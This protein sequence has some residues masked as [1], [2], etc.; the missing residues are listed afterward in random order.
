MKANGNSWR[1]DAIYF[2]VTGCAAYSRIQPLLPC[3]WIDSSATS[4]IA[5]ATTAAVAEK[6]APLFLW[7]NA[8]RPETRDY[9]DQVLCYSHL[10]NGLSVLDSK[11]ALARLF[12]DGEMDDRIIVLYQVIA[13][14]ANQDFN[15]FVIRSACSS[16]PSRHQWRNLRQGGGFPDLLEAGRLQSW[17]LPFS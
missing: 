11:W 14:E 2:E 10:P 13:F 3:E 5:A 9:R 15:Y 17:L 1:R 12:R 7:E 16:R 6:R 8:P 4:T